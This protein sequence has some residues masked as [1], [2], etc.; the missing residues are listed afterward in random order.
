M[1][2]NYILTWFVIFSSGMYLFMFLKIRFKQKTGEN[3]TGWLLVLPTVI[4]MTIISIFLFPGKAGFIGGILWLIF[5]FIPML[6]RRLINRYITGEK[7]GLA[8]VVARTAAILHPTDNLKKM[9]GLIRVLKMVQQ[10]EI[11]KAEASIEKFRDLDN[12][13]DRF[14]HAYFMSNCG[15]F[16]KLIEWV[17]QH[18]GEE[19]L[20][21][22]LDLL[23]RY[24]EALGETGQTKKLI[25]LYLLYTE[26]MS[27]PYFTPLLP[28]CR[29]Y[30]F[31]YTGRKEQVLQLLSGQLSPLIED[32]KKFWLATALQT[33]DQGDKAKE[34]FD[35]LLDS[36]FFTIRLRS[37]QRLDSPLDVVSEEYKPEI[38]RITRQVI[39]KTKE[40]QKYKNPLGRK[41]FRKKAYATYALIA[42]IVFYFLLELHYGTDARSLYRL[43]A[44]VKVYGR[45]GEWWRLITSM[46]MHFNFNHLILNLFGLFI[47]GPYVETSVGRL[48]YVTIY[49]LS[50]L[51]SM[52]LALLMTPKPILILLGASGCIMGLLGAMSY[53]LYLGYKKEKSKIAGKSFYMVVL[54]FAFQVIFDFVTPNISMIAHLSGFVFG[55]LITALL[56]S[57]KNYNPE[58]AKEK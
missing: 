32:K 1:D 53:L 56:I 42:A 36:S 57:M 33:S 26:K 38:E 51:G 9:P 4:G 5:I 2:M 25:D 50:G 11:E 27:I 45:Q 8:A 54:I 22:Y 41:A 19:N 24:L 58:Q 37:R 49:L 55:L 47:I 21:G 18:F 16:E 6:C 10:G 23:P 48:S 43:G 31:A 3:F 30:V 13:I 44:V 52:Y 39:L 40:E 28:L 46:F 12:S 20:Y 34:V 15:Q 14:A 29:L 17:G 7:L 35:D